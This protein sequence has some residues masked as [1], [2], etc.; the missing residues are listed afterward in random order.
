MAY[1]RQATTFSF[2]VDDNE[3][4]EE[5]EDVEDEDEDEDEDDVDVEDEVPSPAESSALTSLAS[6]LVA[7]AATF[8][9]ALI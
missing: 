6:T 2:L 4:Q 7:G 1:D 8:L 9:Y 3:V 5:E